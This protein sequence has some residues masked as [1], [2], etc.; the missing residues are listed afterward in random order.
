MP[1]LRRGRG[2]TIALIILAA[3]VG[4]GSR[5]FAAFLPA[6]VVAYAGDTMWALA[7]FLVLGL[8]FA[9]RSRWWVAALAG[10]IA[11]FVEFSQ[12]YHAPWIDAVRGTVVG[13]L[14]LGSD[15]DP[16]DLAC[17][18]AGVGIGLLIETLTTARPRS[19]RRLLRHGGWIGLEDH[20][21]LQRPAQQVDD[22][23]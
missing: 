14:A 21:A 2:I 18:A 10:L 13:H 19:V 20:A 17:Y 22:R 15:F 5:R 4:L 16:K 23:G 6:V 8:C 1:E 11:A 9:T 3:T 7:V 12:L